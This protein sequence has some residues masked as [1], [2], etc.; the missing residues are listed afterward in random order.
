VTAFTLGWGQDD[1]ELL[2][3]A[4]LRTDRVSPV[5]RGLELVD[6]KVHRRNS[7]SKIERFI[8]VQSAPALAD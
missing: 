8:G 5:E 7:C 4:A 6:W 2:W 1:G 3:P